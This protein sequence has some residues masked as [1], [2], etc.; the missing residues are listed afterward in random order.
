MMV[1]ASQVLSAELA[2]ATGW[3]TLYW[4]N[5]DKY[6]NTNWH[7]DNKKLG[8]KSI[9]AYNFDFLFEKLRPVFL[10]QKDAEQLETFKLLLIVPNPAD[11]LAKLAITLGKAGLFK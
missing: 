2:Q 1:V 3:A 8:E 6:T 5:Q 10:T 9:P 11:S 7:L 4:W